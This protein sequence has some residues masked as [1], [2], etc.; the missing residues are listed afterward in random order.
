MRAFLKA[1]RDLLRGLFRESLLRGGGPG[2]GR[3][4]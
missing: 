4:C 1:V 3:C 2:S